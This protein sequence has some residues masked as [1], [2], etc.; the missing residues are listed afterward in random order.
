MGRSSPEPIG[1]GRGGGTVRPGR[2]KEPASADQVVLPLGRVHELAP[3]VLFLDPGVEREGGAA[4][5]RSLEMGV[6]VVAGKMVIVLQLQGCSSGCRT[7]E[8]VAIAVLGRSRQARSRLVLQRRPA[9][10]VVSMQRFVSRIALLRR[11]RL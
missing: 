5:P 3:R 8:E 10:G 9:Q 7:K 11:R 1:T 4:S 6:V 2:G